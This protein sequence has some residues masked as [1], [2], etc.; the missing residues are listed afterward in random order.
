[1][2]IDIHARDGSSKGSIE[3]NPEIFGIEPNAAVM[4]QAVKMHLANRRQG[5]HKTKGRSEVS[6]GGRKPWRQKGRGVA[7]A[8]TS[9]SPLWSGGG[10]IFG[11]RPHGYRQSMPK[12]M[13]RLA[14][15]SALSLKAR[16]DELTLVDSLDF[17]EIRTSAFASMLRAVGAPS[18]VLVLTAGSNHNA[19][20][21]GRNIAGCTIMTA[22]EASTYDL[23]N[24]KGIVI[25]QG[26][27]EI[28]ESLLLDGSSENRQKADVDN[29]ADVETE[30]Q[31]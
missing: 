23:L 16:A 17:S 28:L 20:M 26:A 21:S 30:E 4:H 15:R 27:L 18:K 7:R 25:E 9:R 10:V 2:N 3:L 1:M 24:N 31:S 22:A 8:G 5:T 6:G 14:R 12:K 19:L 13:R 29:N 11:P